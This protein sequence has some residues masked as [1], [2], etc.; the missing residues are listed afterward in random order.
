MLRY[1]D[2]S[3]GGE[4]AAPSPRSAAI[5]TLFVKGQRACMRT[6]A[7]EPPHPTR[8]SVSKHTWE[9]SITQAQSTQHTHRR[10]A[11]PAALGPKQCHHAVHAATDAAADAAA[12]AAR[13]V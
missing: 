2:A 11:A 10:P 8:V 7:E 6:L 1:G 5:R 12:D 3:A 13:T 9:T 4:A